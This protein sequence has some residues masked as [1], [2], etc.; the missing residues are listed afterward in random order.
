MYP[1]VLHEEYC[2]QTLQDTAEWA[3]GHV[4][5][6]SWSL[7]VTPPHEFLWCPTGV[8]V[9]TD[10]A[11]CPTLTD[12]RIHHT[13]SKLLMLLLI[14]CMTQ[15]LTIQF[16]LITNL[17]CPWLMKIVFHNHYQLIKLKI[18]NFDQHWDCD[19]VQFTNISVWSRDELRVSFILN[20]NILVDSIIGNFTEQCCPKNR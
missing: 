9:T 2:S 16:C 5:L 7:H 14:L 13:M 17:Q 1:V 4:T 8:L 6:Q 12:H 3:G 19:F 20:M 15:K 11:L 18:F 10:T